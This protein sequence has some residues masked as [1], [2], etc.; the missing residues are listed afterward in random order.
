L[1]TE[2]VSHDFLLLPTTPRA[3]QGYLLRG[4]LLRKSGNRSSRAS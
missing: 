4:D 2:I 1:F 3:R